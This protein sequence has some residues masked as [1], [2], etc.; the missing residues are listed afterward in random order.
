[1]IT[2]HS[3]TI[4]TKGRGLIDITKN[5][6]EYISHSKIDIGLCNVFLHH[7]SASLTLGE[8]FDPTVSSDLE[9]FMQRLSPDGDPLFEHTAEGPDDMS[10]HVRSVLTTNSIMIPIT[11]KRLAL[12]TWQG[13]FLWEH[14]LAPHERK[15]TVTLI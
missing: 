15:I 8:N 3:F 2:Q 6:A 4:Q 13:V 7:T 1:M 12:G 5:V 14:R 11:D 10:S 9:A